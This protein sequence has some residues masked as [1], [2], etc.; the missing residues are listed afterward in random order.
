VFAR[1]TT[2]H[3]R[4][5]N[6]DA[7]IKY[8]QN[9]AGPMLDKIDGCRGLSLLVDRETGQCIATS[10]WEGEASML[11]SGEQLHEIRERGRTILGGSMQIDTWDIA[12]MHRSQH[13][14]ACRVSWLE[15][16]LDAMI[17]SFRMGILPQLEQTPG[18]CSASLLVNRTSSLGCAT[19]CWE[20]K[21]A[22]VA[23]RLAAD[24]MRTRAASDAGGSIVDVHEYELAYAH[25][26]VPEMA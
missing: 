12:V 20:T 13:G 19:T 23:S 15:G 14:E 21:S 18:F 10:S 17:D 16:D 24:D 6:I 3:G 22:M 7:G 26:H 8:V 11:A 25:L 5:E 2:F 1:S 9:E 4:P